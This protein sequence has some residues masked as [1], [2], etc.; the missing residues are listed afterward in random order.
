M[1]SKRNN[2]VTTL[3]N[4]TKSTEFGSCGNRETNIKKTSYI[5]RKVLIIQGRQAALFRNCSH[6]SLVLH[7]RF[8]SMGMDKAKGDTSELVEKTQ[9][10]VK[11]KK[12]E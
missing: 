2:I 6:H 12:I 11:G 10:T 3:K 7:V 4:Y 5:L 1:F 8:V 9:K